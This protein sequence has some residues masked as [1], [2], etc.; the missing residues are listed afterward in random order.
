MHPHVVSCAATSRDLALAQ[1]HAIH[2]LMLPHEVE[3]AS[4]TL[5]LLDQICLICLEEVKELWECI[6][7][8]AW[9]PD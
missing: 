3:A 8:V 5:C 1:E 6:E 7:L 2:G 4:A 9:L